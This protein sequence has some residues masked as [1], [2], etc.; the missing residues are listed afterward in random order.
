M[1]AA[2]ELKCQL[3]AMYMNMENQAKI[4]AGL[5]EHYNFYDL[6]FVFGLNYRML[7]EIKRWAPK[8]DLSLIVPIVPQEPVQ[9]MEEMN[10]QVYLC[11]LENLCP[12]LVEHLHKRGFLVDG[13]VVNT[14]A[15][16][17]EAV[18]LGVDMI[19]SDLPLDMLELYRE[20]PSA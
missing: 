2:L 15:R 19:E 14:A 5:L 6:C 17:R 4:I 1:P 9:L 10:A 16:L 8:T 18:A 12:P 20:L 3:S 7:Y 13:S 11:Y